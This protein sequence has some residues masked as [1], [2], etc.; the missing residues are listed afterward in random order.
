MINRRRKVIHFSAINGSEIIGFDL[1][2]KGCDKGCEKECD[3]G[4]DE[5][6]DFA[7]ASFNWIRF[8]LHP[9]DFFQGCDPKKQSHPWKNISAQPAH[10]LAG[11]TSRRMKAGRRTGLLQFTI[12]YSLTIDHPSNSIFT[13]YPSWCA[14]R[15][16]SAL[17]S[18]TFMSQ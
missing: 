17:G 16:K 1:L 5:G 7:I 6:C 13:I 12:I 3:K 4:C 8:R 15:D 18:H 11:S 2:N 9:W 14:T 10:N